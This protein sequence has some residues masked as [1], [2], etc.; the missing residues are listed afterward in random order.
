LVDALAEVGGF[1]VGEFELDPAL[2]AFDEGAEEFGAEALDR[3]QRAGV[4]RHA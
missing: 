1:V 3:L 4:L 2:R